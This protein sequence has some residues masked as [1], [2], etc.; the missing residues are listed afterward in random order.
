MKNKHLED[1]ES[2]FYQARTPAPKFRAGDTV[3]VHYKIQEGSDKEKFRIQPFEGVVIAVKNGT[4]GSSFTVRKIAANSI[5]V[6]RVFPTWS[7]RIDKIEVLTGGIVRRARLY[8]LRELS[9]KAARIKT[10]F[11]QTAAN[12]SKKT[13][14][15]A[16][17][18]E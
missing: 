8:Y 3:K 4:A 17:A 15:A 6:E 13:T 1:F 5:G 18:S 2:R 7:P 16:E 12:T 14:E 9:G 10:R 11:I